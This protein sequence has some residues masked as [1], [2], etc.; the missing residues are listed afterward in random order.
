MGIV[1]ISDLMHDNLRDA[2]D[3]LS[4]SINAQ[5]EH[6][7]RVGML[8]E[9]HPELTYGEI[10]QLMLRSARTGAGELSFVKPEVATAA[11]VTARFG[12]RKAAR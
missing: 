6:W 9:L 3:A 8:S 4:R 2:S 12:V 11:S 7:L 1:K 5:A 10:C